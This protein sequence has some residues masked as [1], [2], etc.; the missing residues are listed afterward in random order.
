MKIM[1]LMFLNNVC[2]YKMQNRKQMD[3]VLFFWK[4]PLRYKNL[5]MTWNKLNMFSIWMIVF[6]LP[7]SIH[8]LEG[9]FRLA[10]Q[11]IQ[12]IWDLLNAK[13]SKVLKI[14]ENFYKVLI[15]SHDL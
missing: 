14:L 2:R 8:F 12:D 9:K 1:V 3:E 4:L 15:H 10:T 7:L 11:S 6:P 5:H 13:V